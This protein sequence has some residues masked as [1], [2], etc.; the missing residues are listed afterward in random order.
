MNPWLLETRMKRRARCFL[1]VT[2]N[3][4]TA[5]LLSRDAHSYMKKWTLIPTQIG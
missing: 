4:S 2:L 5:T 3:N 1:C